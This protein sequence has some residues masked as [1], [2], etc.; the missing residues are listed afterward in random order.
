MDYAQNLR[1]HLSDGDWILMLALYCGV[2]NV[3]FFRAASTWK[4]LDVRIV[5]TYLQV[6]GSGRF[7]FMVQMCYKF[8]FPTISRSTPTAAVGSWNPKEPIS[9]FQLPTIY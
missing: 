3:F 5:L 4:S 7:D 8:Y 9:K 6:V 2:I 1:G